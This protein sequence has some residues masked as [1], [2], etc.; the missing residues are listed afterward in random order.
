MALTRSIHV[1]SVL[2]R[3]DGLPLFRRSG[4]GKTSLQKMKRPVFR[5]PIYRS[6]EMKLT[7]CSRNIPISVEYIDTMRRKPLEQLQLHLCFSG[8]LGAAVQL[9]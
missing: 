5:I 7:H 9:G 4:S 1:R 3:Q 6:M 2:V 8:V